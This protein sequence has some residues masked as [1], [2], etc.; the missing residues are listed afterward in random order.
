M[1]FRIR[2]FQSKHHIIFLNSNLFTSCAEEHISATN[3]EK[4]VLNFSEKVQ[5]NIDTNLS[6]KRNRFI[7]NYFQQRHKIKLFNGNILFAEKG[8]IIAQNLRD[9][10][11]QK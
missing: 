1:Y 3:E 6:D 10:P 8:Q 9:G 11:F 2:V 5:E 7:E 4:E